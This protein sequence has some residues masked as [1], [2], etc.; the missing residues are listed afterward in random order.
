MERQNLS[1]NVQ[2]PPSSEVDSPLGVPKSLLL[3]IETDSIDV[4]QEETQ[5]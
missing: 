3:A 5:P 1:E 4:K 2:L